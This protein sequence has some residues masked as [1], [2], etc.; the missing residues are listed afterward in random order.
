MGNN[1]ELT[2]VICVDGVK[3]TRR[4]VLKDFT[5]T[6]ER[7]LSGV[8]LRDEEAVYAVPI[9]VTVKGTKVR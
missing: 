8:D 7:D 2:A 5:I 4:W 1:V 3:S 6:E 9:Y